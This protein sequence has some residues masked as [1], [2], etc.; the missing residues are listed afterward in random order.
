MTERAQR[1][2]A[3][4]A[5]R[6]A[7]AARI[8]AAQAETRRVV[9]SGK[10]PTCGSGLKRNLSISGWW[11]CEQLGAETHRARPQEPSCSWQGFTR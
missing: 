1:M 3:K 2:A 11:Q 6:A 5:E 8:A 9:E 4:R 7:S 10:C